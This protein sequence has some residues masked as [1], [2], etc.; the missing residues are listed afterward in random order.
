MNSEKQ[1]GCGQYKMQNAD[2]RLLVLFDMDEQFK[3][4][5]LQIIVVARRYLGVVTVHQ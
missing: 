2:C 1:C 3:V 5:R 4:N